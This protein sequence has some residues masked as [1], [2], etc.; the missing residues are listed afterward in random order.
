MT[1]TTQTHGLLPG[2]AMPPVRGKRDHAGDGVKQE[3]EI[4]DDGSALN[5]DDYAGSAQRCNLNCN[6]FAP[7]CGDG[8]RTNGEVCDDGNNLVEECDYGNQSCGTCGPNCTFVAGLPNYCGDGNIDVVPELGI[9]EQC[10]DGD[11]LD[12]MGPC[13]GSCDGFTACAGE[14][15][16]FAPTDP[17]NADEVTVKLGVCAPADK[18]RENQQ[19]FIA[20]GAYHTCAIEAG[21]ACAVL[22]SQWLWRKYCPFRPRPRGGDFGG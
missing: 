22:G 10:D 14:S 2:I 6:G 4:C 9:N 8:N 19:R 12:H 11:V 1:A 7:R 17:N 16:K 15:Y 5:S 3:E 18:P 13:A 20:A 21:G